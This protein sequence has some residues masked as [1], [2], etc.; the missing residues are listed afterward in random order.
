MRMFNADLGRVD[1]IEDRLGGVV[2][3]NDQSV[4][5]DGLMRRR[6]R[7]GRRVFVLDAMQ[8]GIDAAE[9]HQFVVGAFL[10]HHAV[11]QHD[12]LVGVAQRAQAV[13]DHDHGAALHQPL[14][15]LDH[16]ALGLG[17]EGGAWVRPGS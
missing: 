9:G 7:C 10:D 5:H 2:G 15:A 1:R 3:Q 17:V 12:D 13:R 11:L 6:G 8:L 14:Q 4:G 16:Q